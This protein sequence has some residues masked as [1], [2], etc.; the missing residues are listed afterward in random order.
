M[1]NSGKEQHASCKEE[2]VFINKIVCPC[3]CHG[4]RKETTN[5][6][7]TSSGSDSEGLEIEQ[8]LDATKVS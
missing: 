5:E 6:V 7:T 3:S 1:P 8:E 4:V 2:F